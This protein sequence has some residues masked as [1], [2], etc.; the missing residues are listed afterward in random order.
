MAYFV[1]GYI[2]QSNA[3]RQKCD[4]CK[5]IFVASDDAPQLE[6]DVPDEHKLIFDMPNSGGLSAPSELSFTATALA[7]QC[8]TA[9]S[10]DKTMLQKLLAQSNQ[11]SFY[12]KVVLLPSARQPCSMLGRCKML[13]KSLEFWFNCDDHV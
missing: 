2:G 8:C 3:K 5:E 1:A 4:A 9:I 11:R 7:A 6:D 13:N 10:T 12:V